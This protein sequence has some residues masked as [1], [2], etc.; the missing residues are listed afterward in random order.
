VRDSR[1]WGYPSKR[2]VSKTALKKLQRTFGGG[3]HASDAG[4]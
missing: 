2:L 3:N 4:I 1:S